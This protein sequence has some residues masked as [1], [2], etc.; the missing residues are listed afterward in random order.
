MTT[1]NNQSC[2][3]RAESYLRELSARARALWAKT[4]SGEERNLWSPLYV[5][6]GDSACVARKLWSCWLPAS[7]KRCISSFLEDDD[8][9]AETLVCWFAGVH[10]VGKAT[11]GFQFKVPERAELDEEVGLR[12]PQSH[13]VPHPPSHANMGEILLENWLDARG[14]DRPDTFGCVVGAH[15]GAPPSSDGV[16]EDIEEASAAFPIE[17]LGDQDW[18]A[19]QNELLEW[20]FHFSGMDG[21]EAVFRERI[22]P[23]PVQVLLSALVI[24][25]DWISSNADFFPLV[26]CVETYVRKN[27]QYRDDKTSRHSQGFDDWPNSGSNSGSYGKILYRGV[28]ET[29]AKSA[30]L[31]QLKPGDHVGQNGPASF[32]KTVAVARNFADN[33]YTQAAIA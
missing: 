17:N 1:R 27:V 32:S 13:M 7:V 29:D 20:M 21:Y 18:A 24:M 9:A 8:E 28:A 23:Q 12:V 19:S 14:W 4:G 10:D 30:K 5:H 31:Q 11:P 3:C 6:M 33:G 16:L 15:H 2:D 25:A 22:V 26:N